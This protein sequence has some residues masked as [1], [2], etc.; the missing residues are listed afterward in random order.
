MAPGQDWLQL[1]VRRTITTTFIAVP[2]TS[3]VKVIY[4]LGYNTA[5][6]GETSIIQNK[7]LALS[8]DKG[9]AEY[10]PP[11]IIILDNGIIEKGTILNPSHKQV[12]QTLTTKGA[13][14]G[15]HLIA[16]CLILQETTLDLPKIISIPTYMVLYD[17]LNQDLNATLVYKRLLLD[18][19]HEAN[20]L[21]QAK[22]FPQSILV[23]SYLATHDKPY[24]TLE[25]GLPW[26][27]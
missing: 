17:S 14:F 24:T 5:S 11:N 7:F 15:K 10:G 19:T 26:C 27:Q 4:G 16:P 1:N 20:W 6:I 8:V 23:G 18:C 22:S 9:S 21:T 25:I 13:V 3:T 2:D 12:Q